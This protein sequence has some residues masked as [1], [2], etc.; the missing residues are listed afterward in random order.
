MGTFDVIGSDPYPIGNGNKTA[1]G[2]H[3]EVNSTVVLT[4]YARPVWEVIQAMNWHNYHPTTPC[5]TC[6][7]P[8]FDESRSMVWQSIAAGANGIVFYEYNDLLK[9]PDVDFHTEFGRLKEIAAEVLAHAPLIL[10]D[11]GKAPAVQVTG[12]ESWVMTRTQWTSAENTTATLFAVSDGDGGGSVEFDLTELCGASK[13]IKVLR[14]MEADPHASPSAA[15]PTVDGCSFKDAL[16]KLGVVAYNITFAGAGAGA[17]GPNSDTTDSDAVDVVSCPAGGNRDAAVLKL[18]GDRSAVLSNGYVCAV[19]GK[20]TLVELRSDFHGN[21]EWGLNALAA[22]LG[23]ELVAADGTVSPLAQGSTLAEVTG[24]GPQ[25][26]TVLFTVDVG[27]VAQEVWTLSVG[28]AERNVSVSI[29]GKVTG[30]GVAGGSHVRHAIAAVAVST[31]AHFERGAMQMMNKASSRMLHTTNPLQRAYWIGAKNITRAAK[32]I[33]KPYVLREC[34]LRFTPAFDCI[35]DIYTPRSSY[36]TQQLPCLDVS[37]LPGHTTSLLVIESR[38]DDHTAPF[39]GALHD[40]VLGRLD[41]SVPLDTWTNASTF[42]GVGVLQ[43]ADLSATWLR[44]FALTPNNY[45]FPAGGIPVTASTAATTGMEF[46]DLRAFYTAIYASPAGQ[47]ISFSPA[48]PGMSQT[49][50]HSP[51]NGYAGLVNFFDRI[52]SSR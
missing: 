41:P 10:S 11:T 49:S 5:P 27:K 3:E 29:N 12:D 35:C 31:Y 18:V 13:A 30:A 51:L 21:G 42:T 22:P 48:T 33:P 9:N 6:H 43:S 2:V 46:D 45:D 50:L 1:A 26:R 16:P 7:T 34:I 25:R 19:V 24:S 52:T 32:A 14:I 28:L 4:D 15:A 47:L 23:V 37:L 40:I 39:G 38:P 8:T 44:G 20:N 17:E 36:T